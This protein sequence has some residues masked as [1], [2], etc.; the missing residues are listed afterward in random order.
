VKTSP[1]RDS[2]GLRLARSGGAALALL[3]L[4]LILPLAPAEGAPPTRHGCAKRA[5][6]KPPRA[7]RCQTHP[8]KRGLGDR[9]PEQAPD[10]PQS[11]PAAPGPAKPLPQTTSPAPPTPAPVPGLTPVLAPAPDPT[12][13]SASGGPGLFTSGTVWDQ[14]SEGSAAIDPSSGQLIGT[15]L[16]SIAAEEAAGSGPRLGTE[17]R[18]PVYEVGPDQARVPVQLDTGTWGDQLAARLRAGVPIPAAAQPVAGS[19]RAMAVWQPATDTYWEFFKMQQALH[20]PQFVKGATVADGCALPSGSFAY[21]VTSFNASGET[22]ADANATVAK[23][24]AGGACVT[25]RWSAISGAGGYRIYRGPTKASASLLATVGAESTSFVDDG[26]AVP[27]G[28]APPTVNTAA[29]PGEWHAAYGGL[30]TDVSASPGYYRDR[31]GPAGE[32]LEQSNWGSA[33]TGLPLA[34]GLITRRDVERGSIDHAVSI[35]LDNSGA[36]AIL[37]AGQFA[38]PA[39]RTDGL[40]ARPNSIPEGA[41]LLLDPALDIDSLELSPLARMLA[42]A[43]QRYGL[44]VQDGSLATVV[45]AEDPAPYVRAGDPNFYRPLIGTNSV[46][47]LHS[48]PWSQLEVTSMQLCTSRPCLPG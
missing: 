22:T 8:P 16:S 43:A 18:T 24:L 30:M 23:V 48:F 2:S 36:D 37:R 20:G 7:R 12:P 25:I 42:E 34:S 45:Y 46:R 11:Q 10:A 4:M 28:T 13:F 14:P 9:G 39:Q 26:G 35:G 15:L 1:T 3:V 29:T 47:A 5:T 44:I 32:V 33:A 38:F 40:S 6:H 41:R 17:T 27:D 21:V 31:T 19:D